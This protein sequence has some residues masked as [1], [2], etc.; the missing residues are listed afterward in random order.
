[1]ECEPLQNRVS[2]R[3]VRVTFISSGL[4]T[5][6]AEF[7]LLRLLPAMR[8][9]G[10]ESSVV[11]LRSAGTIGPRLEDNGVA[12]TALGLPGGVGWCTSWLRLRASL[13][14][15]SPGLLHGWM[16]HGN[17]VALAAAGRLRLPIAWGIRQSLGRGNRDK[18]LTRCVIDVGGR[19]S[20]RVDLIVYNSAVARKQHEAQ[21]YDAARSAVVPNGFDTTLLRP[22]TSLRGAVRSELGIAHDAPVLAQVARY[23]AGKDYPTLLRA[24]VRV[25]AAL[26]NVRFLLIGEGVERSNAALWALVSELGLSAHVHLLG[27]RDDV[28][29]LLC[30]VDIA[31]LTSAG[32]EGFPNALGEAMSCGAPCVG[33][34]VGD[35]PEL[36]GDTGEVVPPGDPQAV[37][38]AVIRLLELETA[39][40][41]ALGERARQRIVERFG[42]DNVA[43]RYAAMLHALVDQR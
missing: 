27:R 8:K 12:V 35:I 36:I 32:M 9:F 15:F 23:H 20:S 37:A 30:A 7:A 1:M 24:A 5:G 33:T 14:D 40:R 39:K 6:G 29:R 18:W 38:S 13:L 16:Y 11:S 19:M 3:P 34:A 41:R 25:I 21:G 22:N 10:I 31:T 43:S 2:A 28:P 42:I 4:D 26:P 17:L